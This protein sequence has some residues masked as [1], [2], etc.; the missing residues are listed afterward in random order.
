ME[1]YIENLV[2][3]LSDY[4]DGQRF[5]LGI[6]GLSRAGKTSFTNRMK[7]LLGEK[8]VSMHTFHIDD[9]IVDKAKRYRTG[10]KEWIEYYNLQWDVEWLT[11]HFF[12]KL[13]E[14][15]V[16]NLPFYNHSTDKQIWQMTNIASANLIIIEGIFLQRP[17]WRKLLDFVIYLDSSR[18]TRFGR[19]NENTQKNIHKFKTRYWK[20][21]DYYLHTVNPLMQADLVIKNES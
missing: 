15:D 18:E 19:E 2:Y 1:K 21:E 10:H 12:T 20:A 17:E 3:H 4:R 7:Q 13:K 5:I 14:N 11:E 9:F 8:N 16:L 6:D